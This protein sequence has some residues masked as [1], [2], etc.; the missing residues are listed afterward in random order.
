MAENTASWGMIKTIRADEEGSAIVKWKLL[1]AMSNQ[2]GGHAAEKA[3]KRDL[4]R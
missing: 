2:L 3:A 4:R 1:A